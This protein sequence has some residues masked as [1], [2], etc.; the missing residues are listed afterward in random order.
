LA[1]GAAIKQSHSVMSCRATPSFGIRTPTKFLPAVISLGTRSEARKTKVKGPG[2][3]SVAMIRMASISRGVNFIIFNICAILEKCII[4]GFVIGRP[5][6][7][8]ICL[9]AVGFRASAPNPYTVSVGNATNP[10]D[11]ISRLHRRRILSFM[12]N[13]WGRGC[14]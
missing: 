2:Q 4:T 1:L 3:H 9:T 6:Q 7:A 8:N 13:I 10:P 14:I 12:S 11:R 5:F